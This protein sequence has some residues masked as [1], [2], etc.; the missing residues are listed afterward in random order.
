[1]LLLTRAYTDGGKIKEHE[2][3]EQRQRTRCEVYSRVCGYLRPMQTWNEGKYQEGKDR[4][5]FDVGG[6]Y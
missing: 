5:M 1:L 6:K 2:I 4:V 3:M